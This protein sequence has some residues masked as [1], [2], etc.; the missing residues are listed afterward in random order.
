MK[1]W[2]PWYRGRFTVGIEVVEDTPE[3]AIYRAWVTKWEQVF[4]VLEKSG[5]G[6]TILG[7]LGVALMVKVSAPIALA[8]AGALA[9]GGTS[10]FIAQR[11]REA[12][13]RAAKKN[14]KRGKP[15]ELKL[16]T[17]GEPTYRLEKIT[18]IHFRD[19]EISSRSLKWIAL[20]DLPPHSDF[21]WS[22]IL[23][24]VEGDSLEP[25][26]PFLGREEEILPIARAIASRCEVNLKI[27]R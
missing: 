14:K 25:F 5:T 8:A 23:Q 27:T 21:R 13:R 10:S 18:K 24:T 11:A 20:I 26:P 16:E 6:F 7:V 15:F 9:L 12:L 1:S 17:S 3:R 22:L 19:Q 4:N 2:K